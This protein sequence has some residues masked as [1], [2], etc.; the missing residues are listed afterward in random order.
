MSLVIAFHRTASAEFI[1]AS[2][3]MKI[4]VKDLPLRLWLK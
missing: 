4:S 3:W 2:A 1:A